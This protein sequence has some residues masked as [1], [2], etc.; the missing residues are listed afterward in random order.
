MYFIYKFYDKEDK[1]LY[2]GESI[3]IPNRMSAHLSEN[4]WKKKEIKKILY[5]K[6][7]TK[8]DMDLYEV[9]YINK[10]KPKYNIQHLNDDAPSFELP[11]L[12]F[13][14][15][16]HV[17]KI[18]I[19]KSEVKKERIYNNKIEIKRIDS[20]NNF[21]RK[22]LKYILSFENEIEIRYRE[23]LHYLNL[24]YNEENK[25]RILK[26]IRK[27][28]TLTIYLNYQNGHEWIPITLQISYLFD[29]KFKNLRFAKDEKMST[30]FKISFN[31][32]VFEEIFDF[33]LYGSPTLDVE[34]IESKLNTIK[35]KKK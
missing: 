21:D 4:S 7:K 8:T 29:E 17:K 22:V 23:V 18:K 2:V 35:Y 15:Y 27:L 5:A 25:I 13:K 12:E 1:L 11:E 3:N 20:I 19:T 31:K 26:F 24:E 33:I 6:C 32:Y 14:L 9:F 10:L 34:S 16:N 30:S 28:S